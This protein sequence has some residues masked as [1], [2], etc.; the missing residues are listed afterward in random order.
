[1]ASGK[2]PAAAPRGNQS[3]DWLTRKDWGILAIVIAF[4]AFDGYETFAV[5]ITG[6]TSM[7][8][9]LPADLASDAI[10]YF[11]YLLAITLAGWTVGGVAGGI[12]GDRLGRRRTMIYAVVAYGLFTGLSALSPTWWFLAGTRFLTGLGIGA[13]WAVGTSL[14]QEVWPAKYR[15]KGAGLL[16]SGLSIGGLIVSGIWLLFNHAGI[17]WRFI[18]LVGIAPVIAVIVFRKI[19][20]ESKN[21]TQRRVGQTRTIFRELWNPPLRRNLTLCVVVSLA[22]TLGWWA[23]S[24]YLP[25]YVGALAGN[26]VGFYTGMASALY[27]GGEIVGCIAF[28]FLADRFGRKPI[29]FS[30]LLGAF[31][32]TAII[33]LAIKNVWVAVWL[34]ILF[35]YLAGGVFSWYTIHPPEL[36][37]TQVRASAIGFIFNGAR[38]PAVFGAFLTGALANVLGGVGHAAFYIGLIYVAGVITIMFLPETKNQQLPS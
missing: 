34:Q 26:D 4:W 21:W 1:M 9:L 15:T 16:Q 10:K 32:M 38:I 33:F 3:K 2:N 6:V 31:I 12:A 7:N 20:P 23:G 11:G 19:I 35:G 17:S 18:Y 13:E 27:N 14:L 30:Y 22:I 29:G 5:I 37:P 25:S 28:G 36:F 8:D 24:S